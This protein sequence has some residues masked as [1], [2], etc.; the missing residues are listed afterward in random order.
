MLAFLT[1]KDRIERDACIDYYENHHDFVTLGRREITQGESDSGK[2][3]EIPTA[4]RD[5][6][7]AIQ[8]ESALALG[9]VEMSVTDSSVIV[10]MAQSFRAHAKD[11]L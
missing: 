10:P 5:P 6:S 7:A 1:K 4:Q 11:L 3:Q 9:G 8:R 2:A